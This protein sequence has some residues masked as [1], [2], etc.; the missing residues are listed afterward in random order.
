MTTP[1][2]PGGL[3]CRQMEALMPP[4]VDGLARAEDAAAIAAH[5]A[6]CPACRAAIDCQCSVRALLR[7]RCDALKGA[8]PGDLGALVRR[9]S[10]ST[11]GLLG[12]SGRLSA[13][14]AAAACVVGVTAVLMWST[15]RSSV[16]LAAQLTLDHLKCFMIDGD[17]NA[18]A[19]SAQAAEARMQA[20]FGWSRPVPVPT[21]PDVHLVAVRRCLYAEGMVPHVLYRVGHEAVSL[22][23][24][25]KAVAATADVSA[26]GRHAVVLVRGDLTYVIVAPPHLRQVS[27][28]V[29][30]E[31]Q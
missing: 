23:I 26:F 24:L 11:A 31:A 8:A 7:G 18:P 28:L 16:L 10:S 13:L 15:G 19:V 29:G 9:R 2:R 22:F 6:A 12:A 25:P 20:T 21:R 5:L 3:D 1:A 4:Y 30:L 27:A 17:V 14:A